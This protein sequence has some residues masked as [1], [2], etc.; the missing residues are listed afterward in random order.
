MKQAVTTLK[1]EIIILI[2][3]DAL[4]LLYKPSL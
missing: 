4:F 2:C 1:Q 3:D